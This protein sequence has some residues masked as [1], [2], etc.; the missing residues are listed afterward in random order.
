MGVCQ[1]LNCSSRKSSNASFDFEK[2]PQVRMDTNT[3]ASSISSPREKN[4]FAFHY[5]CSAH[6]KEFD[7]DIISFESSYCLPCGCTRRR[8]ISIENFKKVIED[9]AKTRCT[10]HNRETIAYCFECEIHLCEECK[11][12]FHDEY[13]INHH[14]I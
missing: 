4:S 13:F 10:K 9:T 3:N 6:R 5:Y 12:A 14:L 7:I 1:S 8:D 2:D 11:K